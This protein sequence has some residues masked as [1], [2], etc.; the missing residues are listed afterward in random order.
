M[1]P[2]IANVPWGTKLAPGENYLLRVNTNSSQCYTFHVARAIRQVSQS[3]SPHVLQDHEMSK[4]SIT[5]LLS[6][7]KNRKIYYSV[8]QSVSAELITK[9]IF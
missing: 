1:S 5:S 4:D 9:R 2:D 8:L 3:T 6:A 7:Y